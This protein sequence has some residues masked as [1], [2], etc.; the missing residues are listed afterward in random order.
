MMEKPLLIMRKLEGMKRVVCMIT[1]PLYYTSIRLQGAGL[2]IPLE[3][4][5]QVLLDAKHRPKPALK[6]KHMRRKRNHLATLID[7]FMSHS[8][9]IFTNS[10]SQR[11]VCMYENVDL[12]TLTPLFRQVSL[13]K[14][15]TRTHTEE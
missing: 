7:L 11:Y 3:K 5:E 10:P 6:G 8:L 9:S 14:S 2:R 4:V 15:H 1:N 12:D 13:T